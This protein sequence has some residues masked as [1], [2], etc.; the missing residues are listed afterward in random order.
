MLTGLEAAGSV[1]RRSAPGKYIRLP[2]AILVRV[3]GEPR[4]CRVSFIDRDGMEHS[5]QV[6][7]RSRN[8]AA[9]RALAEFRR[10]NRDRGKGLMGPYLSDKLTV[11]I[12]SE[13]SHEV[14]AEQAQDWLER[15][16]LRS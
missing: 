6:V 12:V 15:P 3:L 16:L 10:M 2:F 7:A 1:L 11:R 8:E 14:T 13:E 9:V 4:A 5:V